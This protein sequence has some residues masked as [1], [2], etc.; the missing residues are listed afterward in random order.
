MGAGRSEGG[1]RGTLAAPERAELDSSGAEAAL[2][3]SAAL[4]PRVSTRSVHVL[5]LALLA[6][7]IVGGLASGIAAMLYTAIGI[8]PVGDALATWTR[9]RERS[10]LGAG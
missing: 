10:Q 7:L 3:A 1:G 4:R 9:R 8:A 5:T 2:A 6:V